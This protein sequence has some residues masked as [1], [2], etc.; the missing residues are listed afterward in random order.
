V[1]RVSR[2][3]A[4]H[5]ERDRVQWLRSIYRC[6]LLFSTAWINAS[7]EGSCASSSRASLCGA[8]PGRYRPCVATEKPTAIPPLGPVSLF[9]CC[10][11]DQDRSRRLNRSVSK[12]YSAGI[13]IR[14][15]SGGRRFAVDSISAAHCAPVRALVGIAK[16]APGRSPQEGDVW[17]MIPSAW[18]IVHRAPSDVRSLASDISAADQIPAGSGSAATIVAPLAGSREHSNPNRARFWLRRPGTPV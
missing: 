12:P 8:V 6:V 13:T 5:Y 3:S 11:A 7:T 4:T 14:L 2:G 16:K 15:H 18:L 10:T 17:R 9:R 1:D